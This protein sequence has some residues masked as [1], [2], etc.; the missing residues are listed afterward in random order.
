MI[1]P[2]LLFV[3]LALPFTASAQTER[4]AAVVNEDA[5]SLSDLNE[6]LHM[7]AVS[8]G[9]KLNP[10]IVERLTPQ[11]LGSLIEEQLKLQEAERLDIAVSDENIATGFA[12][13]AAQ[14]KMTSEQFQETLITNHIS[15]ATME[16]QI[17]SQIAW[18]SV[19]QQIIRPK[20]TVS[21][22]DVDDVLSRIGRSVG[23]EE[24]LAA[25][26]FLPVSSPKEE[27]EIRTLAQN[28]TEQIRD[29]KAP[30]FR[31]A[32]QF[33]KAA[34]APQGGDLGW[35]N[36]GQLP[37]QLDTALSQMENGQV[38]NPIRSLEGYHILL[39][40][41]KRQVSKDALPSRE[42]IM[43]DIGLERLERLQRGHLLDLKAAA[44]IEY[45]VQ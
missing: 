26:I 18:N 17:K 4:I 15:P 8:S 2:V 20:I 21:D 7:V 19:V 33:S 16:R 40:R 11:V 24:Y 39:L 42:Q 9:L 31:V 44:F 29:Q 45:R 30:F 22:T 23:L 36:Q 14:N 37:E 35:I 13:L 1:F 41:D 38:S 34:G 10:E 32:Q 5:I 28:L 27:E 6:R 12:Q 43:Q 25:E 3:L